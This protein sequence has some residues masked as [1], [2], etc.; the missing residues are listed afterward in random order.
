MKIKFFYF[1][2][3]LRNLDKKRKYSSDRAA[4][5]KIRSA[6]P[7]GLLWW[8]PHGPRKKYIWT[9]SGQAEPGRAGLARVIG[10]GGPFIKKQI[11]LSVLKRDKSKSALLNFCFSATDLFVEVK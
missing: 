9:G 11:D 1:F 8:G 5:Q 6:W 7:V 4:Q 3:N 2:R 10:S